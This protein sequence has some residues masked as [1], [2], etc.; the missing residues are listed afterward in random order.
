MKKLRLY[1][2]TSVWNFL[3]AEDTPDLKK[4]TSDFF[5]EV[6]AGKYEIYI[7]E[8]VTTEI[9]RTRDERKRNNLLIAV[10]RYNP[11]ILP[12]SDE[13]ASF[14]E[15]LILNNVIP[16]NYRDDAVHIGYAVINEID[17][18]VSWN[19]SHIVKLKTKISVGALAELE[20]YKKILIA[21]PGEVIG[22]A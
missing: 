12:P 16:V 21:T 22:Y 20:G 19:L 7:S 9:Y 3:F 10:N 18:L 17:V 4:V 15:K 11:I 13:V 1:L 6:K 14:A 5:T 2:E 8:L